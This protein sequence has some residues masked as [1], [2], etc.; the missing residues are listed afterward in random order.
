MVPSAHQVGADGQRGAVHFGR[1]PRAREARLFSRFARCPQSRGRGG[2]VED[3]PD[4][5]RS[6]RAA[7]DPAEHQEPEGAL[8]VHVD[9]RVRGVHRRAE[10]R[11]IRGVSLLVLSSW[12]ALAE[13]E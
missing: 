3:Q 10:G 11:P 12:V 13:D 9:G 8:E 4:C 6:L 5:R 2:H 1:H 7:A